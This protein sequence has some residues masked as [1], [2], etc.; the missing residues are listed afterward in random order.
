MPSEIDLEKED[1]GKMW[2]SAE[3]AKDYTFFLF[4]PKPA[5][6]PKALEDNPNAIAAADLLVKSPMLPDK[7]GKVSFDLK[8][9]A[10]EIKDKLK[11]SKTEA[12][13]AVLATAKPENED[14]N[15]KSVVMESVTLKKNAASIKLTPLKG[16]ATQ[17]DWFTHHHSLLFVEM[18]VKDVPQ[19]TF[20]T[21]PKT[22]WFNT[23]LMV[24]GIWEQA[25]PG[26]TNGKKMLMGCVGQEHAPNPKCT[27][28]PAVH[29]GQWWQ[30][31]TTQIERKN[32]PIQLTLSPG[33]TNY[34]FGLYP[35]QAGSFVLT[36]K[37]TGPHEKVKA[38]ANL[39]LNGPHPS[40][41]D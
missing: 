27:F 35:R 24:C 19:I 6:T 38:T 31:W 5:Y 23:P 37:G 2:A 16:S 30:L 32:G 39:S 29:G 41:G 26:S 22:P 1:P 28:P 21:D 7:S 9:K 13:A 25:A 11:D 4:L 12:R 40:P 17:A 3:N 14:P 15:Q 10:A 20:E 33:V 34:V 36:V 8:P 18:V